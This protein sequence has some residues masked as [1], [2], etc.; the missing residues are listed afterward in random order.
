MFVPLLGYEASAGSGKTFMLVVRY[1]SLLFKGVEPERILALTFTNK[2]ASEMSERIMATIKDLEHKEELGVIAQSLELSK[3]SLLAKREEVLKRLYSAEL[4]I[5]TLDKFFALILRKFS[6]YEGLQ[7]QFA[8][9]EQGEDIEVLKEMLNRSEVAKKDKE[10]IHLALLSEKRLDG[11]FELLQALYLKQQELKEK[12]FSVTPYHAIGVELL[13]KAKELAAFV[14][15]NEIM[16]IRAKKTMQFEELEELFE[17]SW[18]AKES[19]NYWDYKKGYEPEMDRLLLE[20]KKLAL[21]YMQAKEQ[22]FFAHLFELLSLYRTSRLNVARRGGELSFDDVTVML[23][24]LLNESIHKD[25]L[26][27]RLDARID[28]ILL[29][30]FQDTSVIQYDILKP[31]IEEIVSGQGRSDFRSFFYVGDTKQSIYRFRGGNRAL[32]KAV[33]AECGVVMERLNTNYRSCKTVVSFVNETFM[34][35]VMPGYTQAQQSR[36]DADEGYVEVLESEEQITQAVKQVLEMIQEGIDPSSMAILTWKNEDGLMLQEALEAQSIEVITETSAKLIHHPNIMALI[37][38]LKYYYFKAEIFWK[39]FVSLH[40]GSE[41]IEYLALDYKEM[42]L[43]AFI[44]RLIRY[45][46]LFSGDQNMIRFVNVCSAY[47]D[48][49]HLIFAINKESENLTRLDQSGVR[50]LTVHKSKGLEFEHVIVLDRLGRKNS[51]RSTIL[52]H[53]EGIK[54]KALYLRQKGREAL[55]EAYAEAIEANKALSK[56]DELNAMYVAFTRAKTRLYVM[57]KPKSSIFDLLNMSVGSRGKKSRSLITSPKAEH[58]Q[59]FE[60][61][62]FE[63]GRQEQAAQ[64]EHQEVQDLAAIEYGIALHYALEMLASFE[65]QSIPQAMQAL[66]NR[67]HL[68]DKSYQS[69]QKRLENLLSYQ[70]FLSLVAGAVSKEQ[71]ISIEG[72]LY[73]MDLLVQHDTHYVIIDYKSGKQGQKKHF[74]QLRNYKKGLQSIENIDVQAYICYLLDEGIELVALD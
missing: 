42:S 49:D 23:Y 30:E 67:Y 57:K 51:D 15:N 19:L 36:A 35:P 74:N 66:R 1:L 34:E 13:K 50:I 53:Y 28:H 17:K 21:A 63:L 10:L 5:M 14:V 70:P 25:F 72:K 46:G 27:F 16:S 24:H 61:K 55:D 47:R 6:L 45:Y 2:A 71:P 48:L 22:S 4:K 33:E 3:E 40:S 59:D 37:E 38:L 26:Y 43:V 68:S 65:L 8:I 64:K 62:V 39:N 12:H 9:K 11:I 18:L 32:F 54:L 58:K 69:I 60:Y 29:D 73:Y 20:V 31:L 41:S 44:D 52:Y 7:P 56:E